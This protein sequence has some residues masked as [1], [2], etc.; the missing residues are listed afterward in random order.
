MPQSKSNSQPK[1]GKKPRTNKETPGY[2]PFTFVRIKQNDQQVSSVE[3][4]QND[5]VA[6]A[7]VPATLPD[8]SEAE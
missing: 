4:A 5:F 6:R 2:L 3:E 8:E 1:K 7:G